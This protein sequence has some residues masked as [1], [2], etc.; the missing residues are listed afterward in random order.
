[1]KS[2]GLVIPMLLLS[3]IALSACGSLGVEQD[4][5]AAPV[6]STTGVA[7]APPATEMPT[8][9]DAPE[10]TVTFTPTP[11]ASPTETPSPTAAPSDTPTST[12]QPTSTPT[13]TPPPEPEVQVKSDSANVR[14][15]PGTNFEAVVTLH[16]GDIVAVL[17]TNGDG[18]WYNVQ[19]ADGSTG[20]LAASVSEPISEEAL[21][22]VSVAATIPAPPSIEPTTAVSAPE[23][24]TPPAA[25]TGDGDTL[26]L[27]FINQTPNRDVEVR[28]W[29]CCETTTFAVLIGQTVVREFPAGDYG[30]GVQ[31][32]VCLRDLPNIQP[33]ERAL[34]IFFLPTEGGC[35]W[36]INTYRG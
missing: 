31:S 34:T 8:S 23:P 13:E 35:D 9:T 18:S 25:T 29:D 22:L 30:W 19:L 24:T 14:S 26:V 7:E 6:A 36:Y 2:T 17:A 27:T 28:I 16:E 12:P 15:G 32:A 21:A 11:T 10:P 20:W 5:G 33:G 3:T 1:M 4:A